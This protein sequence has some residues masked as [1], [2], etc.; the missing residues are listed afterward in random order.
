VALTLTS[1]DSS[2]QVRKDTCAA[3]TPEQS[4]LGYR[5]LGNRCEGFYLPRLSGQLQV[6]SFT[7]SGDLSFTW[8]ETTRLTVTPLKTFDAALNIRAVSL[9]PN[10]FYRMDAVIP[11][12]GSLNWPIS[13]YLYRRPIRPAQLGVYGWTGSEDDK[14][15]VPTVLREQD[16]AHPVVSML[17]LKIRTVLPLT[18]FRWALVNPRRGV[19]HS[20]PGVDTFLYLPGP[21][22]AGTI[23]PVDLPLPQSPAQERCLE[24]QYRPDGRRWES[25]ILKIRY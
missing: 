2:A 13:P 22:G 17:T 5:Q 18:H 12:T 20:Q 11:G 21:M 24:I 9:E 1:R 23:I 15:F 3:L 10:V 6:V 8:R 16:N 25:E 14:I 7:P 4:E 19:C